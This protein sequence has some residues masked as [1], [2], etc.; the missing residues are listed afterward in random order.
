MS[1]IDLLT[2]CA[3]LVSPVTMAAIVQQESQGNPLALHD[4]TTAISLQPR[5]KPEAIAMAHELIGAGHSVDLGLGQINSRNLAGLGQTVEAMFE[6][7][8]NLNAAQTVLVA[9]WRQSGESLSGA[10]AAYNTGKIHSAIGA[11]YATAVQNQAVHAVPVVP[12]IPGGKMPPW[13]LQEL[14]A[15][16]ASAPGRPV[17]PPSP[18]ASPLKPDAGD[19]KPPGRHAD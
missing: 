5:N 17:R 4:N 10:L 11:E 15:D 2:L 18:S 19:L 1:P 16:A 13:T 3:P 6:P 9:A 7:C 14:P 8:A 12:A